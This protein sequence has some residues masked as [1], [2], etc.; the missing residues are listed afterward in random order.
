MNAL[1]LCAVNDGAISRSMSAVAGGPAA[2]PN[3][4]YRAAG[5]ECDVADEPITY[6]SYVQGVVPS[7][8]VGGFFEGWATPLT[9]S[10]HLLLL[11]RATH[12]VLAMEESTVVGFVK[13]LSDGM[14]SAYIPL[15]EVVPSRRGHGIGSELIRR[16]PVDLGQLYTVDVMCDEDLV[17]FYERLGVSPAGGVVRRNYPW[18]QARPDLASGADLLPEHWAGSSVLDRRTA[19]T[20]PRTHSMAPAAAAIAPPTTAGVQRAIASSGRTH[21]K[22]SCSSLRLMVAPGATSTA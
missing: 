6:R 11:R 22:R 13:A 17:S 20:V 1:S 19:R 14:L 4:A 15:L 9:P 16:L 7:S 18:R 5:R 10:E 3:G 2:G 12:V 8:L 21:S